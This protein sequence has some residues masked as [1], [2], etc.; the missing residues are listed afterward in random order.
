MVGEER[1]KKSIEEARRKHRGREDRK[2][3]REE[4]EEDTGAERRRSRRSRRS[5]EGD[6]EEAGDKLGIA[7]E[8]VVIAAEI[9]VSKLGEEGTQVVCKNCYGRF[10]VGIGVSSAKCPLCDERVSLAQ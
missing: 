4:E 5:G 3:E 10:T 6:S 9:D 8:E 7:P 1:E 2:D